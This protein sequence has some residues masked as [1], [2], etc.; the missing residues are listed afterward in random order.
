MVH[1]IGTRNVTNGVT[2]HLI[3]FYIIIIFFVIPGGLLCDGYLLLK[4]NFQRDLSLKPIHLALCT[5]FLALHLFH[6]V[7]MSLIWCP[8]GDYITKSFNEAVEVEKELKILKPPRPL[9]GYS[10][11]SPLQDPIGW[12]LSTAVILMATIPLVLTIAGEKSKGHPTYTL[13]NTVI[14]QTWK[15]NQVNTLPLLNL[16]NGR[17]VCLLCRIVS[18]LVMIFLISILQ[19]LTTGLRLLDQLRCWNG[20]NLIRNIEIYEQLLVLSMIIKRPQSNLTFA[21]MAAGL[22]LNVAANYGTIRFYSVITNTAKGGPTFLAFPILSFFIPVII[23]ATLPKAVDCHEISSRILRK[24]KCLAA[25]LP[26]QRQIKPLHD[27]STGTNLKERKYSDRKLRSLKTASYNGGLG[28]FSIY[29]LTQGTK[30]NYYWSITY[31]TVTA[32]LSLDY[33]P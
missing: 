24:W 7:C 6:A 27:N 12:V 1:L 16:P 10:K 5:F 32:V 26:E 25:S 23:W 11:F 29:G 13:Y 33:K 21:L 30:T 4:Q 17:N 31:Y 19:I 18:K 9:P 8:F 22:S 14:P 15:E 2:T 20:S 3:F 28:D